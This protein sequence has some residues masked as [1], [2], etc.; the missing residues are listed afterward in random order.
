MYRGRYSENNTTRSLVSI[1][2]V[3]KAVGDGQTVD[4]GGSASCEAGRAVIFGMCNIQ[5][6]SSQYY[7]RGRSERAVGFASDLLGFGG[8]AGGIGCFIVPTC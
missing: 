7:C 4:L 2:S 3:G 5:S 6:R 1:L 8:L